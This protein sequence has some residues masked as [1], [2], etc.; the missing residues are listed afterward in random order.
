VTKPQIPIQMRVSATILLYWEKRT[1]KDRGKGQERS[2]NGLRIVRT[3]QAEEEG[4]RKSEGE[5]RDEL[6][7]RNEKLGGRG[8]SESTRRSPLPPLGLGRQVVTSTPEFRPTLS[9]QSEVRQQTSWA[10][11]RSS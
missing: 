6:K 7:R 10:A 2:G 8:Y 4:T 9:R 11:L 1:A 3:I 5:R